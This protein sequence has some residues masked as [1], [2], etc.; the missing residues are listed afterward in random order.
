MKTRRIGITIGDPAGIGPQIIRTA[1][2]SPLIDHTVEYRIIGDAD[3]HS[4]GVPTNAS[5]Q[6]AWDALE[7]SINLLQTGEIDGVVTCPISKAAMTRIGFPHPGH[8]EFFA[9]KSQCVDAVS[10]ILTGDSLTVGLA[11]IHIP[12]S[13]I[14]EHLT[15]DSILKTGRHLVEFTS[16]LDSEKFPR[17]AVA[18]LNPHAGESGTIG[19][20]ELHLIRPAVEIL[21]SEYSGTATIDGPFSPD[22]IFHRAAQGEWDAVLCMYHDQGLIPL[23][24]LDFHSGVNVTW[25]LPFIRTSPDH[26][27]AYDLAAS[28]TASPQSLICAINLAARLL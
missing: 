10:M 11:T 7:E 24:L 4:A 27:T 8:T 17:I 25:G 15:R 12:V 9:E 18:G 20:E 19:T 16:R 23:K 1:L 21:Q 3:G 6:A 28:E 2:E 14:G 13:A 22:T 26:G 5:A